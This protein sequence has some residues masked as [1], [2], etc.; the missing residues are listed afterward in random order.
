MDYTAI[1]RFIIFIAFIF[2]AQSLFAQNKFAPPEEITYEN[3]VYK[4]NFSKKKD[5]EIYEYTT[6]SETVNN[7]TT[8]ITL[9][10]AKNAKLD[11]TDWFN[12]HKRA[13]DNQTPKPHYSLYIS[14]G[15]VYAMEIYE[16]ILGDLS[17]EATIKKVFFDE[18]CN[19]PLSFAFAKRYPSLQDESAET[20]HAKL[21]SIAQETKKRTKELETTAWTPRCTNTSQ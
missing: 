8:L 21:I 11:T 6:D 12:N 15:N 5:N 19:A 10:Y 14:G 3:K 17:Y 7:W 20:K 4:L 9:F 1:S 16:P 13:L 18:M 2:N